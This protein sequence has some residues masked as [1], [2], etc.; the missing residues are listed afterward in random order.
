MPGHYDTT[1]PYSIESTQSN[2]N[3]GS[4]SK[5]DM[6]KKQGNSYDNNANS[7]NPKHHANEFAGTTSSN[8]THQNL[9]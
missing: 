3:Y 8:P 4:S 9:Q 5:G 7:N 6:Q 2:Q 1:D